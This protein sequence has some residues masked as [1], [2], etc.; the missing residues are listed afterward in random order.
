LT[1]NVRPWIILLAVSVCGSA[2]T[3]SVSRLLHKTPSKAWA[4][5]YRAAKLFDTGAAAQAAELERAISLDPG[6]PEAHC[7]L[8]VTYMVMERTGD[9]A[10]EFRKAI[11]L[12]PGNSAY[13]TN[14]AAALTVLGRPGEGEAEAQ[15]AVALDSANAQAHYL[16]GLLLERHADTRPSAERHLAYAGRRIAEAREALEKLFSA[17]KAAARGEP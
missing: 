15:T 4:S 5:F 9:A 14:M 8:G 16:L 6:F 11:E 13:H 12:D 2:Q 3:V 7:N 17:E 1:R 10:E